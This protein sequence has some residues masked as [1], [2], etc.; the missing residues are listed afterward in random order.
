M[1]MLNPNHL[2]RAW[3][4]TLFGT[5]L[6]L[7][8]CPLVQAQVSTPPASL[9][10][11]DPTLVFRSG[12]W[13]QWIYWAIPGPQAYAAIQ[14]IVA[15]VNA[16]RAGAGLP[17]LVTNPTYEIVVSVFDER[18]A[19]GAN[20]SSVL[21]TT[22]NQEAFLATFV[23]DAAGGSE[24]LFLTDPLR[25]NDLLAVKGVPGV[26]A[27]VER[28]IEIKSEHGAERVETEWRFSSTA[29]D[30][31]AFSAH[32]PSSAI[33]YHAVTP[34]ARID[35]AKFNLG[36][37][38]DLIYRSAPTQI[39]PLFARDEGNFID[40]AGKGVHA[41]VH[42]DHHDPDVNAIFN[43]PRNVP[44]VLIALDRDVRIER[45]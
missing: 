4:A 42:I 37:S 32:Y 34:A 44:E 28:A 7:G 22:S 1:R 40:L 2:S 14:R 45:R 25:S 39:F 27:T 29:G 30:R 24:V 21:P 3:R 43:D 17:L 8:F 9:T 35:Y 19:R 23:D 26:A 15:E 12:L 36:H 16:A 31:I 6:S 11:Q 18:N 33:Y 41:R 13:K 10:T 38:A 20:G 5:T